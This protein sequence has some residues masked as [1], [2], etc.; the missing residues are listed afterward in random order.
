MVAIGSIAAANEMPHMAVGCASSGL[1]CSF[2]SWR[3]AFVDRIDVR[4]MCDETELL[5]HCAPIFFLP[6][7]GALPE[8]IPNNGTVALIEDGQRQFL[9]TCAH[10]WDGFV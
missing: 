10:V 4:Q 5:H 1:P 8:T 3:M 7:E 9:V 6:A 2:W